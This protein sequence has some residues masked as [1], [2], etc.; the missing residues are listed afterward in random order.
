MRLD[1]GSES[2]EI[3]SHFWTLAG[4]E[5]GN[6]HPKGARTQIQLLLA[7]VAPVD[8]WIP[9]WHWGCYPGSHD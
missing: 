1:G 9:P 4:M 8:S 2:V 6:D 5:K 7:L 3:M